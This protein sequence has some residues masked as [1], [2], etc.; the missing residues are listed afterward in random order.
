MVARS[1]ARGRVARTRELLAVAMFA[2]SLVALLYFGVLGLALG[3][4][5]E[6]FAV[7]EFAGRSW[8]AHEDPYRP[9]FQLPDQDEVVLFP[10]PPQSAFL[11]VPLALLDFE[12]AA[13]VWRLLNVVSIAVIVALTVKRMRESAASTLTRTELLVV[14]AL[15]IGNAFTTKVVWQGQTSLVILAALMAAWETVPR[16]W[17]A[18]AACLAIAGWKPQ[19]AVLFAI[20]LALERQWRVLGAAAVVALLMSAYPFL[21]QGVTDSVGSWVTALQGYGTEGPNAPGFLRVVTLQSLL[22]TIGIRTPNL[23]PVAVIFTLLLWFYR[24]RVG[25]DAVLALLLALSVTF[26]SGHDQDYVW[27]I[28]LATTL[29]VQARHDPYRVIALGSLLML[30]MI[31]LRFLRILDLEHL[32]HWRTAV[33]LV[34]MGLAVWWTWDRRLVRETGARGAATLA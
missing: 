11:L 23:A 24:K 33:V 16:H 26:I 8:L 21:T 7:L 13:G 18:A 14:A 1:S 27:L 12:V 10:Y 25:K 30:V 31:P 32:Y 5:D 29:W 9:A 2:A 4:S 3:P 34:L 6:D 17:L 22:Y 20:W 19:V 28:P 15:I